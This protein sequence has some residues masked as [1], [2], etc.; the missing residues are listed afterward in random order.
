MNN[1]LAVPVNQNERHCW[2]NGQHLRLECL[3]VLGISS[4]VNDTV[5]VENCV[6]FSKRSILNLDRHIRAFHRLIK[7]KSWRAVK[8]G[9]KKDCIKHYYTVWSITQWKPLPLLQG[10]LERMQEIWDEGQMHSFYT[11]SGIIL[12]R[13][14]KKS[15]PKRIADMSD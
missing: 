7:D 6:L 12:T 5:L 14:E 8:L 15:P 10:Y 4:S 9:Y 1:K 2:A 13:F 3:E 11:I